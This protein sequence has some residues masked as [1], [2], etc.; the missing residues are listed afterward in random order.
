[1]GMQY[2]VRVRAATRA[3]GVMYRALVAGWSVQQAVALARQA[4][5][6]EEPDRA[7]WYVPVLYVRSQETAPV[8]LLTPQQRAAPREAGATLPRQ[9]IRASGGSHVRG[10]AMQSD[11]AAAQDVDA[12]RASEIEQARLRAVGQGEQRIC[13]DDAST[14]REVELGHGDT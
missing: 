10:V 2:A 5:Y 9:S 8:Y 12:S 11:G 4:L 7:S 1:M 6:V 3:S 13:A 14:I